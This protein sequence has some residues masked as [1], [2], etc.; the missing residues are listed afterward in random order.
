LNIYI[1]PLQ[2]RLLRG[3]HNSSVAKKSSLQ[4]REELER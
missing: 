1:A 4:T 3:T 2:E